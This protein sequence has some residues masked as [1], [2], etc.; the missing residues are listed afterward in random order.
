MLYRRN[1]RPEVYSVNNRAGY[2]SSVAFYLM[3]GARA[4]LSLHSSVPARARVHGGDERK[5][6]RKLRGA[7][8][9]GDRYHPLFER[10]S[11][12]VNDSPVKFRKFIEEQYAPMRK[13]YL[14]GFRDASAAHKRD[15]GSRMMRS[16]K[17]R[18]SDERLAERSGDRMNT[19]HLK[20][21]FKLK[22]RQD[23]NEC[24]GK[25]RLPGSRRPPHG[26][27]VSAGS[28]NLE[29]ALRRFLS[30]HVGEI[31]LVISLRR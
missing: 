20:R 8:D 27:I 23:G 19:R 24:L 10:F 25:K 2:L 4:R 12:R 11:Q 14:S 1:F 30:F 7:L 31:N 29:P 28:G 18:I 13:R 16:A 5:V 22:R 21:L 6:G 26:D 3:S 15:V 9:A 17:R